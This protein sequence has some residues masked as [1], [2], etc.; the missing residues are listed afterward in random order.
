MTDFDEW[1]FPH[2]QVR[3]NQKEMIESVI[4][5]LE[6][7]EHA[8]IE[9]IT[10]EELRTR[11]NGGKYPPFVGHGYLQKVKEKLLPKWR[12][13]LKSEKQNIRE[14]IRKSA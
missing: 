12:K 1:L 2:E 14:F 10:D 6:K 8:V 4:S 9:L 13:Y 3:D 7:K 11:L 5:C